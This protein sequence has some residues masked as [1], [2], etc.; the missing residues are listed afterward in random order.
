MHVLL[1]AEADPVRLWMEQSSQG[2]GSKGHQ[3]EC[4]VPKFCEGG[5]KLCERNKCYMI[6][7][8]VVSYNQ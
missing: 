6:T 2:N 8:R 1:E 3:R 4:I 5:M 7:I